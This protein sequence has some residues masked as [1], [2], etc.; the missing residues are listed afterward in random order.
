MIRWRSAVDQGVH[1]SG[2]AFRVCIQKSA[3]TIELLLLPMNKGKRKN[4]QNC[5]L[6]FEN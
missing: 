1:P 2:I 3:Y 5:E 6:Y 4:Q